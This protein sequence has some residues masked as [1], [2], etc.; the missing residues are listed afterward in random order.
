MRAVALPEEVEHWSLTILRE[1]LVKT[2]ARIARCGRYAVFQLTDVAVPRVLF[3]KIL[4]RIPRLRPQAAPGMR[5]DHRMSLHPRGEVRP[6]S[7]K[8]APKRAR[9]TFNVPRS[10]FALPS[11]A[12]P[13]K[14]PCPCCLFV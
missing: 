11:V 14:E 12:N 1:R 3:E 7:H 2:G 6:N 13:K 9:L 8:S 5:E 4:H 10:S